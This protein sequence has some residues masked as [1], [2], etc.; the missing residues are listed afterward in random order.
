M[1]LDDPDHPPMT[2]ADLALLLGAIAAP[3]SIAAWI[4]LAVLS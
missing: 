2:R 4:I 1:M 3:W